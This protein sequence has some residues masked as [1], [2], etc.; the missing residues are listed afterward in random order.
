M[1]I[2][3]NLIPKLKCPDCGHDDLQVDA[4]FDQTTGDPPNEF[5]CGPCDKIWPASV[6][7]KQWDAPMERV[8]GILEEMGVEVKRKPLPPN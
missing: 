3:R 7:L 6:I 5:Y 1:K 4:E 2:N 8:A